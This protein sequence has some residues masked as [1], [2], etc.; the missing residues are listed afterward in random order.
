MEVTSLRSRRFSDELYDLARNFSER[1]TCLRS[2]FEATQGR[3]YGLLLLL[4][5]LP[6]LSPIP[7]P[8]LSTPFGF[9]VLLIGSRL[10]VGRTPWLPRRL[11]DREIPPGFLPR[12]LRA[13][14]RVIR[15]LE[16]LS[17][18]RLRFLQEHW[19]YQRIA[20]A[21]IAVSGLLLLLPIPVPFTNTFPALPVVLL[22]AGAIERDGLF[23]IGGCIAFLVAVG[24]FVLLA[25]GG[26]HVVNPH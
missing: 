16:F 18:P 7:F 10:A 3:G 24:Y 25:M 20:G 6:F 14:G 2:I 19:F 5:A 4:I 23:F 9:V 22:S 11:L 12:L 13:S 17:R 8:G 1:P 15:W 21:L 26:F